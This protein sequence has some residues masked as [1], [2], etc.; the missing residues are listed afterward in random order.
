MMPWAF[1]GKGI[2]HTSWSPNSGIKAGLVGGLVGWLVGWLI[3]WL[4]DWLV[5]DVVGWRRLVDFFLGGI[6]RD[7]L[8]IYKLYIMLKH[9]NLR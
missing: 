1:P 4:V 5:G 8:G 7:S 3:G 6:Y 2:S 9:L